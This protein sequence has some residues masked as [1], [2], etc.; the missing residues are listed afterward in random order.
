MSRQAKRRRADTNGAAPKP[1]EG[2]AVPNLRGPADKPLQIFIDPRRDAIV[3]TVEQ[4]TSP[5]VRAAVTSQ[6]YSKRILGDLDLTTLVGE[7]S[8]QCAAVNNGDMKRPEAMLVAQ[9]HT[10]DAIFHELARRAAQQIQYL[11][12]LETY[13]RLAFKAQ[14]QCRATLETL[15]N[16]K[17]PPASVAFVKQANI[18]HG[19]QQV[20]NGTTPV[21][22]RAGISEIQQSK[23]LETTNGERLDFGTTATACS[24]DP[25]METVGAINRT[26]HEKG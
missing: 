18:A 10:L 23:L 19:P 14:S 16:I 9:A 15:S 25:S 11:E 26:A 12:P 22:T 24:S 17:N 5:S 20:N 1:T 13:M 3:Q 7:F 8:K 2:A 21:A 4:L 6:Q